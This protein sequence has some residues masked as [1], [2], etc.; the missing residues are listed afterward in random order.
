MKK[1][2]VVLLALAVA[3][4]V[5]ANEGEWSLGGSAMVGTRVDLDPLLREDD[6]EPATAYS[7]DTD[8]TDGSFGI[9]YERDGIE[10]GLDF[11]LFYD[12]SGSVSYD[13]EN[14]K[15]GLGA[16]LGKLLFANA[17][18]DGDDEGIFG[19]F[20]GSLIS[21]LWGSY[22][23]LNEMVHLE[24]AYKSRDITG[25]YWTSN[26]V[27]A[28]YSTNGNFRGSYS[29]NATFDGAGNT[30]SAFEGGSNSNFLLANLHLNQIDFG[31][32]LPN[33]FYNAN[34]GVGYDY[35]NYV[36]SPYSP[37]EYTPVEDGKAYF[38]ADVLKNT[39]FGVKV[40]MQ[41]IEF[42][43]QILLRD[44]AVYFGGN[45]DFGQLSLGAS[46]MGILSPT[47][48]HGDSTNE[49]IMKVGASLDY[50]TDAFGAG[51][52]GWL[53]K[54]GDASANNGTQIGVEPY[55]YYN[56]IPTNLQF[57]VD[58][59]FIFDN[60]YY[61][62][63]KDTENSEVI[64]GLKPQLYWNFLGTGAGSWDTGIGVTY[65]MIKERQN[66]LDVI[67]KFSF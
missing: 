10:V 34:L 57:R 2:L 19:L 36:A 9:Y 24:V 17:L 45:V 51:L 6:G 37:S 42:A 66:S 28:F 65:T 60:L 11:G 64:W 54:L 58:A 30:F 56:V 14:F 50:E 53:S 5:F 62:A 32:I 29:W 8:W 59:S 18:G 38:V 4:G 23:M 31:I 40:N 67:F 33:L 16:N 55:F 25:E 3:G 20:A 35:H 52:A 39:V 15:F 46:F 7:A 63:E 61:G 27:G 44:Y 26:T 12:L 13:G 43:A 1:I 47:D 22:E 48:E 49:T 41:P 21:S